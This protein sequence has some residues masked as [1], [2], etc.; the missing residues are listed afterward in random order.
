M[1]DISSY[2]AQSTGSQKSIN[3]NT[4]FGQLMTV[5]SGIAHNIMLYIE[6]SLV[7]QNKYTAQR[8]KSVLGLAAQSGY[9]PSYGKAAGVWVR[10]AHKVNNRVPL[11]VIVAEHQ[12]ILCS[13]NGLYYNL[14]LNKAATTIKCDT[15]LVSEYIYAVQGQ[16]DIQRFTATG[17]SLYVQ[18][19]KFT[20][21]IDTDYITVKVNDE[22]WEQVASLY[23]MAP[24]QKAYAIRYNPV[25]GIDIIFGNDIN[26]RIIGQGDVIE[27][28]YL[29][30]DGESGN[31]D[32]KESGYF[33][34][35]DKL[36]DVAGEEVDGNTCFDISFASEDAVAAGA[37]PESITK[38]RQ[39]IGFNTRSLVLSDS[40]AYKAFL[41]KFSFVG[42]NRTWSEPGSLVVN[43]LVM[44]NYQLDMQSGEDYFDL[45][46]NQFSLSDIQKASIQN[47]ILAS[48]AQ[49][50]GTT[51]NIIDIELC[52]YACYLYIKL[53]DSSTDKSLITT[54][55]R[56]LV[57]EFFGDIQSDSY[58]PKSDIINLIKDNI[59]EVD[60]VNCYFLSE[61]NETAL[62]TRMY[63]DTQYIFDPVTGTYR[64][65]TST[66]R[67]VSG[68]NPMLG[69]D[70][71]GNIVVD[72]DNQFPVLMG[73][74]D[75]LNS[76]GQEVDVTDPLIIVY[77]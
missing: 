34:F 74:W 61:R 22:E 28:S 37:N 49:L 77:E 57:G 62:Q 18:N 24:D 48:G 60:G 26:G 71:H 56:T 51:Y 23:D 50:A 8:K 39:M 11:D 65:K 67:L 46:P 64:T 58:I 41:N 5:V 45:R 9:Q 31:I 16:F 27:V 2:L 32:V 1:D 73:G 68:E 13:Q 53:K 3:K 70:A 25:S 44:R 76:A 4:V 33:L 36:K 14:V 59:D 47:A 10:I 30:H 7:E 72:A 29:L 75:F 52:K 21:Y 38:I 54:Q 20:G 19:M 63:Q 40:N 43:S 42:Y 35:A 17:G 15:N 66:V 6:D 12:K 69:L 55:I